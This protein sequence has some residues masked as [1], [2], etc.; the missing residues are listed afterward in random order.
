MQNRLDT[1]MSLIQ[2]IKMRFSTN[3]ALAERYVKTLLGVV[4]IAE[5]AN[6]GT[7]D[8]NLDSI[9]IGEQQLVTSATLL[10]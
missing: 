5:D 7:L 9:I 1:G 8:K 4:S 3:F 2:E 10:L 6:N